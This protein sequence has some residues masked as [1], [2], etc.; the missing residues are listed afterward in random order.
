MPGSDDSTETESEAVVGVEGPTL[1]P[2]DS[3]ELFRRLLV[4]GRREAR[5]QLRQLEPSPNC[6]GCR[7]AEQCTREDRVAEAMGML[8]KPEHQHCHDC[9]GIARRELNG[10]CSICGGAPVSSD[11]DSE[12][13]EG[14]PPPPSD[15]GAGHNCAPCTATGQGDGK[16]AE[17][18]Q[19]PPE[20]LVGSNASGPDDS[21]ENTCRKRCRSEDLEGA[22]ETPRSRNR[23]CPSCGL[24]LELVC[25][26]CHEEDMASTRE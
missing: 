7:Q 17:E 14:A 22:R 26:M 13:D 23:P 25:G 20:P 8:K 16:H 1:P 12:G 19:E 18:G 10:D 15:G 3:A 2:V 24:R 4:R 6:P 11:G 9:N 21:S 5:R